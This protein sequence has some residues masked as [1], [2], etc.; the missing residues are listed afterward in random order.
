[1]YNLKIKSKY[2][3][4]LAAQFEGTSTEDLVS[5]IP[6]RYRL[7]IPPKRKA[8]D[9]EIRATAVALLVGV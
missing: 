3:E 8:S 4:K 9:A 2:V 1:M 6:A 7:H 5:Q